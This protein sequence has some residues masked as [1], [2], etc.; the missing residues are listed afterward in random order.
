MK[1]KT[2][3]TY[4]I[5]GA[6]FFN[7]CNTKINKKSNTDFPPIEDRYLGQKP[8]G[9]TPELFA[10]GIVSTEESLET[11]VLFLP[12]MTELSFNRSSGRNGEPETLVVMEY[13]GQS[14]NKKP[15]AQ[16]DADKY[17]ERFSPRYKELN[18][19]EP[20][21]NIPIRGGTLSALSLIHI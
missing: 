19:Q 16:S 1:K 3:F 11:E 17:R 6:L 14:W 12:D 20:F 5:A 8:P 15:I 13:N 2:Y 9:L 21:K 18:S 10:P 7:S 4:T